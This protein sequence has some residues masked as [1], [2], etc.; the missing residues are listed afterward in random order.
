MVVL[1]RLFVETA[2]SD[3]FVVISLT[4]GYSIPLLLIRKGIP[5]YL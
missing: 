2:K 4:N 3:S 5:T 1:L